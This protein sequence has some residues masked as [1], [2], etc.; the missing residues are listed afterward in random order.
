MSSC[1]SSEIWAGNKAWLQPNFCSRL[2]TNGLI[3]PRGLHIGSDNDMLLVERGRGRVIRLDDDGNTIVPIATK[4]G[5]NHGIELSNGY[6]YASTA[7]SVNRWPYKTGQTATSNDNNIQEV[8]MGMGGTTSNELG[9]PGGHTTRTLAFDADGKW[10]YVSI[11]S[12][13]NVDADSSRSRIRRFDI[14]SWDGNQPMI[15]NNGE[16]FADGLRNEVGLAFDSFGDLWGVENGADNLYRQDLGGD[17]HNDNPS[18]ELN[19]FRQEQAGQSFGYPY[20]WSEYC[21]PTQNGGSGMKGANTIWAWP[22]FIRSGY[23]DEWCR[24]NTNPSEMSMPAH[25]APLGITFYN[26]RDT[27]QDEECIGSFPKSMDKYAFIAYHGSWNRSPPTG[28]K[29]VYIPFDSS[30]NPTAL[31]IDLFRHDSDNAKWPGALRPVDVQFDKCGRLYVTE[32]GTGSVIEITY[33]GGVTEETLVLEPDD[34]ADG[35]SCSPYQSPSN[36]PTE[37]PEIQQRTSNPTHSST[38]T[39]SKQSN[40]ETEDPGST[41]C[42]SSSSSSGNIYTYTPLGVVEFVVVL[43]SLIM[44]CFDEE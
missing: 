24:T 40:P 22:S 37:S 9:A 41:C 35:A 39:S 6:L 8:I 33:T 3:K 25:S 42:S 2:Y 5:L 11:G 30:G 4:S 28:F 34:V 23:T 36:P 17:I 1:V 38:I 44:I 7:T 29:V 18:E 16:I 20:C 13:G 10:L 21:L 27:S 19:R 32:D 12:N 43:V 26:W 14:S 15:F 31:P